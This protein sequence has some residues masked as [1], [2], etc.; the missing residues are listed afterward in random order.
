MIAF[1]YKNWRGE[2]EMRFVVPSYIRY[3]TSEYHAKNEQW[4]LVGWDIKRGA[5][6]DF[7]MLDIKGFIPYKEAKTDGQ[8]SPS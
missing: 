3:G 2:D 7:A 1:M 8:Q 6:R 4:F 5:M